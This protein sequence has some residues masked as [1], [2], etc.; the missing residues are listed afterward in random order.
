VLVHGAGGIGKSTL[1]REVAR[2]ATKRGWSTRLVEG[3][4]LAPAPGEL[5]RALHGVESLER[6]LVLFDTYERMTA[7]GGWLRQRL[8]PALP[9]DALVVL[10]GRKRP[11]ADWFQGGWEQVV[12]ELELHP[13]DE[14][15]ARRVAAAHG[16]SDEA[17][18]ARLV[19]WA[20]GSPLALAL[21]AE[22]ARATDWRPERLEGQPDLVQAILRRMGDGELEVGDLDV[23]A[24]ASVARS[25]DAGCCAPSSRRSTPTRSSRGCA[26]GRSPS[27]SGPAS[28]RTSSSAAPCAPTCAAGARTARP[29][30][31][32]S[33]PTTSTRAPCAGSRGCCPT[34]PT[35]STTRR[36]AGAWA[37]RARCATAS[38]PCARRTSKRSGSTAATAPAG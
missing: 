31:A 17:A 26:P 24:V 30:C 34:W 37:P 27:P 6:P 38:T 10:A 35:S 14:Q 5:E 29:S 19:D 8:L 13:F 4:D 25:V 21:G 22:A 3:R 33:S 2:R 11:E 18:I 32:A 7:M 16:V 28:R 23:L 9:S 36:C 1:L 20:D 15:D 12:A